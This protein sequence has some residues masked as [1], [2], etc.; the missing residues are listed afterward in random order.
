MNLEYKTVRLRPVEVGDAGYILSLRLDGRYNRFLSGVSP[1]VES[2]IR[3]IEK[4]KLDEAAKKQFYFIIE[5]LDGVPCG[6]VRIY[7]LRSGSFCWG[8]WILDESKTRYAAIESALL[9]YR[10]GFNVLGFSKSHFDVMK[11]NEKVVS[12]HKKMGAEQVSDDSNN[13]YF[14]I[15]RESVIKAEEYFSR[16][17]A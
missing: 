16:V 6:T 9:V 10:F 12:F 1:D 13:Y 4:Y 14:E 17:L 11:G 3:W 5:R 2:Q 7:D 15:S 8:S